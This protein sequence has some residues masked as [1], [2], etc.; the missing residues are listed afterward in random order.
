MGTLN[1][2]IH[3]WHI[4]SAPQA[5]IIPSIYQSPLMHQ[6]LMTSI[7]H[8]A[9]GICHPSSLTNSSS[10]RLI[11]AYIVNRFNSLVHWLLQ[12][13]E[14]KSGHMPGLLS[15]TVT[16]GFI[17]QYQPGGFKVGRCARELLKNF[18]FYIR[19]FVAIQSSVLIPAISWGGG[20]SSPW[21]PKSTSVNH[22]RNSKMH[23]IHPPPPRHVIPPEHGVSNSHCTAKIYITNI[24]IQ[25]KQ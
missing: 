4:P 21:N 17:F 3:A 8:I 12:I 22:T 5:W 13:W 6:S 19:N 23:K 7:N 20:I 25:N 9:S 1:L 18:L 11:S 2:I 16:Y 10:T 24:L 15:L 14:W